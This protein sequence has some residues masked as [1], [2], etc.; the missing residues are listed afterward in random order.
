MNNNYNISEIAKM[1][2]IT[3]NKIRYYEKKGL[4]NLIRNEDN[5]YRKFNNEDI[6]KLQSILL[7]RSV[8][9]SIKEIKDIL[10]NSSTSNF[11]NHFNNQWEIV[12]NEIQ[13]LTV[14]RSALEKVLDNL[15]EE[16]ILNAKVDIQ[17]VIENANN[18]NYV[19]NNWSDKWNF[20]NWAKTYD[21]SVLENRGAIKIYENYEMIL[22]KVYKLAIENEKEDCTIL[23]IG[24]GTANLSGKF[25]KNNYD[26]VGIDQ[27][28]EMLNIAKSKYPKLKVRLGEFLKIPY[29][30]KS[31]DVIVSTYAF[32]HLNEEE[33]IIAI[34][35]MMRVLKDNG[36][37]I[38]GDL[39]F[40]NKS[41]EEKLLETLNEEEIYE[42]KDE[43]YSYVDTL[44]IHFKKFNKKLRYKKIDRFMYVIEII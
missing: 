18:I 5:E 37:I 1:F 29:G 30:D 9:L 40:K 4:L 27:S 6:I 25:L 19:K 33:K 20:D 34:D 24:V 16:E 44:E 14:I 12:N 8:G 31:F 36:K 35:E 26:I 7:Y 21:I 13:R 23:E 38:I 15:Y 41:E 39:M 42:I 2:N 3:T 22:E 11:L 17:T 43:Y 28:R 10:K 32:H